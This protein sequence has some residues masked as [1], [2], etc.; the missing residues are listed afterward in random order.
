MD[1]ENKPKWLPTAL[2]ASPAQL[3]IMANIAA[4]RTRQDAKWGI[5]PGDHPEW[6]SIMFEEVF[7]VS[8]ALNDRQPIDEL[9]EELIQVAAVAVAWIEGL[10]RMTDEDQEGTHDRV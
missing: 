10:D 4:E 3:R 1:S 8:K 6:F 9:R 7:E 5:R 2:G